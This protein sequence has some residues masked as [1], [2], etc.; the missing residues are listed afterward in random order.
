[1]TCMYG[2]YDHP[3]AAQRVYTQLKRAGLKDGDITVISAEPFEA[4]GF[5]HRDHSLILFRLALLGGILG[6]LTGVGLTVGTEHAWPLV[7]GG[8]PIVAWW[9]NLIVI[10]E[11]TMLGAILTTVVSLLV[12]GKLPSRKRSLYDVAVSDGKILVGVPVTGDA[13]AIRKALDFEAAAIKSAEFG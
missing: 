8:M 11:M 7:T 5:S 10:F 12:T 6:F 1:M 13:E 2:L 9:P 4:F 3:A